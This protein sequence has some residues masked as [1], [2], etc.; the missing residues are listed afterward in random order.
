[1]ILHYELLLLFTSIASVIYIYGLPF[2]IIYIVCPILLYILIGLFFKI[3]FPLKIQSFILFIFLY[4]ITNIVLQ[5]YLNAHVGSV[6]NYTI[7]WL[8]LIYGCYLCKDLDSCR[9]HKII[10]KTAWITLAYTFLDA[11]WRFAHPEMS[12]V[13]DGN[14]AFYK[15]K[16]NSLMFEDSNFVGLLLV[17][18]NGIVLCSSSLNNVK[19]NSPLILTILLAT[20]LTFSRA[21]IFA[22]LFSYILW[23][24]FNSKK[25]IRMLIAFAF[26]LSIL[27]L[28]AALSDDGSFR[29]KFI[30]IELFFTKFT[31]LDIISQLIGV[32]LSNTFDYIGI[33][34]HNILVFLVF[35]L[36]LLGGL[37][38]L[39]VFLMC[40]FLIGSS[41]LFIILPFFINGF[42][43]VSTSIPIMYLF[44]GS[45]ISLK[46]NF[47]G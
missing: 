14:P 28:F 5:Y 47:R 25:S 27:S 37:L 32:G 39:M 9:I 1:M 34:A 20:I 23:V 30:I 36:G 10:V 44:L 3:N 33:G 42:S 13:F 45:F 2:Q 7:S 22:I 6:L 43:L 21:S 41:S 12:Q 15:Y 35:E 17:S 46:Q 18:I 38:F 24:Y 26:V 40:Y 8:L 31:Q 29:S 16:F 4:L 11:A 19:L